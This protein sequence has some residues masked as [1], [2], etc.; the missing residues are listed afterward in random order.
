MTF[1]PCV[2]V[3]TRALASFAVY[4]VDNTDNIFPTHT[5]AWQVLRPSLR[6]AMRCL[7]SH[8][9][10]GGDVSGEEEHSLVGSMCDYTAPADNIDALGMNLRNDGLI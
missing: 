6:T 7:A 4:V 9:G 10:T 2:A 1:A 3:L 8:T 5:R